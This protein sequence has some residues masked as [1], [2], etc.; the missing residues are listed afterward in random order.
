MECDSARNLNFDYG[1]IIKSPKSS[2]FSLVQKA[3]KQIQCV[4]DEPHIP[5]NKFL[6][7][8]Y[9]SLKNDYNSLQRDYVC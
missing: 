5:D 3:N 8:K 1:A 9:D 7:E 4:T 2:V 6:M